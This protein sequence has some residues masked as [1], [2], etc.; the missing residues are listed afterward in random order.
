MLQFVFHE[1]N[2]FILRRRKTKYIRLVNKNIFSLWEV[3]MNY[4]V[5]PVASSCGDKEKAKWNFKL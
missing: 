1:P 5:I 3:I 2:F 4:Y